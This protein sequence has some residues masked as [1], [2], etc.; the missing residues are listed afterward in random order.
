M[1]PAL[2][3]CNFTSSPKPSLYKHAYFRLHKSIQRTFSISASRERSSCYNSAPRTLTA[4]SKLSGRLQNGSNKHSSSTTQNLS[5]PKND[6]SP[7]F[8]PRTSLETQILKDRNLLL[9]LRESCRCP[10]CIDKSTRQKLFQT[11]DIPIN[12]SAYVK[13]ETKGSFHLKW[14]NDIPGFSPGHFSTYPKHFLQRLPDPPKTPP[15]SFR[16][17]SQNPAFIPWDASTPHLL[18]PTPYTTYLTSVTALHIILLRL[19]QYGVAILSEVPTT[20]AAIT[21]IAARIGPLRSTFY[22]STWDVRSVPDAKNIAYTSQPLGLHMDLLYMRNPPGLQ[23]LHCLKNECSGG[24]SLFADGFRAALELQKE[25]IEQPPPSS[26]GHDTPAA[27]S[28]YQTLA[29]FPQP[30]HYAHPPNQHYRF[31]HPLIQ[32][33]PHNHSIEA[34]NYSPPFQAPFPPNEPFA[35]YLSAAKRFASLI[36]DGKNRLEYRLQP[37]ECVIFDNRR[38]LHGRRGFELRPASDSVGGEERV[39]KEGKGG[40]EGGRWLRGAYI[41]TDVFESRCRCVGIEVEN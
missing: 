31:S 5:P 22:G 23:L 29:T 16:I 21:R 24:E 36:E 11:S 39:V 34:I 1:P 2:S 6:D 41:D 33:H 8:K 12:I 3:L 37:R 18:A 25:A 14:K 9:W 30:F 17:T 27:V 20:P 4:C 13:K 35:P 28:H 7:V 15:K 38:V 10:E 40:K 19:R 26:P 32:L